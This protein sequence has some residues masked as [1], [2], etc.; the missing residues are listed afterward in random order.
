MREHGKDTFIVPFPSQVELQQIVAFKTVTTKNK[1]GVLEFDEWN[2]EIKPKRKLDKVWVQVY[3]V[4]HEIR[5]Y[6]S[7]WAMGSIL[8]ATQKVDMKYLRKSG[9]VRLLVAVLDVIYI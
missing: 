8:V 7:L 1:E 4:P 3:G 9:V 5:S 6:L 2:H